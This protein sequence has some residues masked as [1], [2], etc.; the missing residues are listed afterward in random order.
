MLPKTEYSYDPS[1]FREAVDRDLARCVLF[2]QLLSAEPGRKPPDLPLGRVG[3]QHE[4][5]RAL[6]KTIIQ[7]RNSE[8]NTAALAE[9]AQS[10]PDHHRLLTGTTVRAEGIVDFESAVKEAAFPKPPTSRPLQN[11]FV[12]IS[13]D[14]D[15]RAEAG[16]PRAAL[17]EAAG[18]QLY[19]AAG[20]GR[21]R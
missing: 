6:G 17:P 14:A 2:V 20:P 1:A 7:W 13:A 21:S 4:R 12:Y 16:E 18:H 15:D 3:L 10:D 11:R 5:A 9:V 19:L 8:M